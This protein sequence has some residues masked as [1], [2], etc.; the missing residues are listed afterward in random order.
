MM[1]T[2]E[3]LIVIIIMAGA[4]VAASTYAVLPWPREVSPVNLRRLSYTTLETLDSNYDLSQA[5]FAVDNN[6]TW[7]NLQ[8][9]LSASLPPNVLYNLTVYDVGNSSTTQLYTPLKTISNS[10]DL[11]STS[12]AF[13]YTVASS[14]V[15]FNMIPEKIGEKEGGTLYI[16]N[17]SDAN[18]WWITG[19]TAQ[20][21]ADDLYKMLSP[22]FVR[23][24]VIQDTFQLGKILEGNS[25]DGEIVADA[26]VINTF[27]EAVP[28]PSA[29][30]K[31]P[32]SQN[33]YAYYSYYLGQKVNQY[34]WTW[35]SIVGYPFYYVSNTAKFSN[36]QNDWGIYGMQQTGT[37]GSKAF[38]RGLDSQSYG[39]SGTDI[40]DSTSR[41]VVL[42][43]AAI[44][45]SNYYGIYPSVNQT[46]TRAI[47]TSILDTY[48]LSIGVRIFNQIGEYNPGAMY[49]H[50][51]SGSTDI[52]GSLLALGLTRTPDVRLAA[53]S[54]LSFYQ[55]QLYRS[56]YTAYGTSRLVILQLG[57]IGGV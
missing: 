3:V 16:L 7:I 50:K 36:T 33:N 9:A 27:G 53:L 4:F 22:Y 40:T 2:I 20:S 1:R 10:Q 39:T 42:S 24:I 48:H 35:A 32:Y 17:C 15:T 51:A 54:L 8:R 38:L 19:Y 47:T 14:S 43:Q 12:D 30:C 31:D 45:A 13:S 46:S 49:N 25:L 44:D 55:P 21:L 18:G 52:T 34:N 26:V 6:S 11:G 5:A 29:Y 56:E 37:G 57:L 41:Q 23:T 28:I